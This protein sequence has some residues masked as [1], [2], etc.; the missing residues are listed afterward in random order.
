MED[1]QAR[2]AAEAADTIVGFLYR[3]HRQDQDRPTAAT[4][5][6]EDNPAFNESLDEAFGPFRIHEVEFRPSE[7]LF[8]LEPETYRIYLAEFDGDS[9]ANASSDGTTE[10]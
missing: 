5:I 7:V 9:D 3:V 6:Y 8:S 4:T 2:L 1:V 10:P